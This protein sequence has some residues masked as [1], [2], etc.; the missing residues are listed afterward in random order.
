[1]KKIILIALVLFGLYG[2]WDNVWAGP[3]L[4]CD[5]PPADQQ[6]SRYEIFQ[7]GVSLGIVDAQADGSREPAALPAHP[8]G[9][10]GPVTDAETRREKA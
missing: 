2:F 4:I 7:D 8:G 5:P 3:F 10:P 6:V 1:M 9:H